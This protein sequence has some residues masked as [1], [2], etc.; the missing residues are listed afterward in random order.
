MSIKAPLTKPLRG[1]LFNIITKHGQFLFKNHSSNST[2]LQ[3]CF[4]TDRKLKNQSLTFE[5]GIN[6]I[7]YQ[8]FQKIRG[9]KR[10]TESPEIEVIL[11][12]KKG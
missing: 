10:K 8:S 3:N 2:I 11:N 12:E 4:K 1:E 5:K 7:F 9:T 6:H